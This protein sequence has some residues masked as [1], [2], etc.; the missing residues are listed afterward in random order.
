MGFIG[1]A[2]AG[3]PAPAEGFA[4]GARASAEIGIPGAAPVARLL[5]KNSFRIIAIAD[6]F[7]SSVT[8][9]LVE[10]IEQAVPDQIAEALS[11][12]LRQNAS[13]DSGPRS[14]QDE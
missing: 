1:T 4:P 9:V 12:G 7:R 8:Q 5:R 6:D 14:R 2:K 13:F 11:P 3:L 10:E